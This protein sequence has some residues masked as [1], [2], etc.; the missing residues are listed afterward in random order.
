[1]QTKGTLLLAGLGIAVF[2]ASFSVFYIASAD[3]NLSPQPSTTLEDCKTLQ[4]NGENKVGFVFFSDES[5]ASSYSKFLLS[6]SPYKSRANDLNF[7]YI[8]N[9]DPAQDCTLYRGIALLCYSKNLIAKAGSC[10]YNYIVVPQKSG[11][12][13]RSS[14][15]RGFASIN[16]VQTKNVFLHESGHLFGLAEE[17]DAHVDPPAGSQNCVSSCDSFPQDRSEGCFKECSQA[18]L[19]RSIDQGVMR[20]LNTDEYGSFDQYLIDQEITR[21]QSTPATGLVTAD[22]TCSNKHYYRFTFQ[23][24]DGKLHITD[25]TVQQGCAPALKGD[26]GYTLKDKDGTT[27][28]SRTAGNTLLFTD[29]P[30]LDGIDGET[31]TPRDQPF[32]VTIPDDSNADSVTFYD[33]NNQIG[34]SRL[35]DENAR[36]CEQ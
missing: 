15:Y 36:P 17:Y 12:T 22:T 5:T 20:T 18:S 26:I 2:L 24:K 29:A 3:K 4:Y 13:I 16:T 33:N 1:M 6:K 25:K 7:F 35:N 10:P 28:A 23:E 21:V 14:A 31:Y 32:Y 19:F 9:Y 34:E 30:S 27:L 8:D 11:E